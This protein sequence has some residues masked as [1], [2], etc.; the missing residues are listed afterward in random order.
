MPIW[1]PLLGAGALIF[2]AASSGGGSGSTSPSV[3]PLLGASTYEEFRARMFA[4]D[5]K[6]LQG[7]DIG[8][9][10]MRH[11]WVKRLSNE[12]EWNDHVLR[13]AINEGVITEKQWE[14]MMEANDL[15]L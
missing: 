13:M 12:E 7:A 1:L 11:P 2:Y 14:F 8:A 5:W 3:P 15:P 6:G 9:G 4:L 10:P